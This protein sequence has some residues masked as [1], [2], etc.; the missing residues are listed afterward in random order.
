MGVIGEKRKPAR[1]G[2]EKLGVRGAASGV[3]LQRPDAT[4]HYTP[5]LKSDKRT[6]AV[7]TAFRNEKNA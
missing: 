5:F 4:V 6:A 3:G 1:S 7:R 2:G